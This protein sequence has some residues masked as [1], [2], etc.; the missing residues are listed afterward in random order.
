MVAGEARAGKAESGAW[1]GWQGCA[2]V[3]QDNVEAHLA[4]LGMHV[5]LQPDVVDVRM[6]EVVAAAWL[7]LG[8]G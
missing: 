7:G 8:L 2:R 5:R 6:R 3:Y 1:S 4:R